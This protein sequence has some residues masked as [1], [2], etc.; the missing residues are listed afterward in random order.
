MSDSDDYKERYAPFK[1]EL[2]A[3]IYFK[4]SYYNLTKKMHDKAVIGF[5][6]FEAAHMSDRM[7]ETL[8]KDGFIIK[9]ITDPLVT[10]TPY[11]EISW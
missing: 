7:K 11:I 6:S 3:D 2:L 8:L 1:R 4:K 5:S 10:T 9:L